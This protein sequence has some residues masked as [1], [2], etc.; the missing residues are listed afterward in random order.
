MAGVKAQGLLKDI[1]TDH[2]QMTGFRIDRLQR[3]A[4]Y[5][6][7]ADTEDVLSFSKSLQKEIKFYDIE[8]ENPMSEKEIKY[9]D[10]FIIWDDCTTLKMEGGSIGVEQL[11]LETLTFL[12][13][14]PQSKRVEDIMDSKEPLCDFF[15]IAGDPRAYVYFGKEEVDF[16]RNTPFSLDE[17]RFKKNVRS[18][19]FILYGVSWEE[20]E[21]PEIINEERKKIAGALRRLREDLNESLFSGVDRIS[22]TITIQNKSRLPNLVLKNALLRMCGRISCKDF[23]LQTFPA[24]GEL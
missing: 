4:A 8:M 11:E 1:E 12:D 10:G 17:K 13:E 14:N 5:L 6:D 3:Q 19:A 22:L 21:G 18:D 15:H 23:G 7:L 20:N 9:K 24:A 2:G 16:I